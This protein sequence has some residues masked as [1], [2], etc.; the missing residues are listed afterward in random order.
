MIAV[1]SVL[2]K[3]Y[4]VDVVLYS[5]FGRSDEIFLLEVMVGEIKNLC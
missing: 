4:R 3:Q 2:S 1:L 5:F